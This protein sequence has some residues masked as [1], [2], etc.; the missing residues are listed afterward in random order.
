MSS[1]KGISLSVDVLAMN[2]EIKNNGF[3]VAPN[4]YA[5]D[6]VDGFVFDLLVQLHDAE[7]Q[8]AELESRLQEMP[9]QA[10]A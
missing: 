5:Q 10:A 3:R 2:S 8:I 6:Q 4:G 7:S 9:L 1:A